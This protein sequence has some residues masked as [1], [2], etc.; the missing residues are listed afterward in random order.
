MLRRPVV[1]AA[2]SSI[3]ALIG[4][5]PV[6]VP[7]QGAMT[8]HIAAIRAGDRDGR[9]D[10]ARRAARAGTQYVPADG[11]GPAR[12]W[13]SAGARG[14]VGGGSSHAGRAL[15][16]AEASPLALVGRR[17]TVDRGSSD[18]CAV[19]AA[20]VVVQQ[21]CSLPAAIHSLQWWHSRPL[22]A[23]VVVIACEHRGQSVARHA[24]RGARWGR[25]RSIG[26]P[27]PADVAGRPGDGHAH[28]CDWTGAGGRA[29]RAAP[30]GR[31]R[32]TS[33]RAD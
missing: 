12:Q 8:E 7:S 18:K 10:G 32:H 33:W 26:E 2:A 22:D 27:R 1:S 21:S 3:V 5:V 28:H 13:G 6:A 29:V 24:G 16:R 15:P 30:V 14:C 23:R 4:G 19:S 31:R 9:A 25:S 17:G 11:R 20:S